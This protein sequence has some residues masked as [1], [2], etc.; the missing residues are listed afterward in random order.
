MVD[1]AI[2]ELSVLFF[3]VATRPL[4]IDIVCLNQVFACLSL[5]LVNVR[6]IVAL[7]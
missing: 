3:L 4:F 2:P 7:P 1:D 5:L 6:D